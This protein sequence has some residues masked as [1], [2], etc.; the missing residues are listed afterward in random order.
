[1]Q[2]KS[3]R[4]IIGFFFV[5]LFMGVMFVQLS[6]HGKSIST[7]SSAT[8]TKKEQAPSLRNS[9]KPK[10]P[11]IVNSYFFTVELDVATA[12][13]SGVLVVN[14]TNTENVPLSQLVFHVHPKAFVSYGGDIVINTL[15]VEGDQLNSS[16]HQITD[17]ILEIN[18]NAT[19][20]PLKSVIITI[21]FTTT[22]PHLEDRFGYIL[23]PYEAYYLTNWYPVLAVYDQNGWDRSPYS[24]MG[25]SFYY[26]MSSYE[27]ILTVP[28]TFQVACSLPVKTQVVGVKKTII[29][30]KVTIRDL[31]F[32]ASPD[33]A[34]S[35]TTWNG[36]TITSYYF[37][38]EELE[39][40]GKLATEMGRQA[41]EIYSSAFG[42]YIWETLAIVTFPGGGGME[43]PG[44]VLIA[45]N[46]YYNGSN[47]LY[48][49]EVIVHEIAHQYF[50]F[51][52]GTNSY[53]E[54]FIDE[55]FAVWTS[56]YFLEAQ[57][58]TDDAK[59]KT[60]YRYK[61][62]EAYSLD[63]GDFK[64]GS[65]MAY[66]TSF[67]DS[68]PYFYTVYDK[69]FVVL[70]MLENYLGTETFL[71]CLQVIYQTF[72]G[73]NLFFKDFTS[74]FSSVSHQNLTWFFDQWYFKTGLPKLSLTASSQD[75]LTITIKV[76]NAEKDWYQL[77]LPL[78]IITPFEKL[79]TTVW[80]NGS[81]TTLS[82]TL[83]N[84]TDSATVY[85]AR[86]MLLL[87]T[88][89]Q[90]PLQTEVVFL[91]PETPFPLISILI[92]GLIVLLFR[93]W[94]RPSLR[95]FKRRS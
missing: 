87:R 73:S 47:F 59:E 57:N 28:K 37:D 89:Y 26:D 53:L 62:Y 54:P 58:R 30:E 91:T 76:T 93:K 78:E 90:T 2:K 1:M 38:D 10:S 46:T 43:Y 79:V 39:Y 70:K 4:Q 16:S 94:R 24:F 42:P 48:W 34:K 31:A 84:K 3:E 68:L 52:L 35:S 17:T 14:Y 13:I 50:P 81:E 64:L 36:T 88:F 65:S 67:G 72:A 61:V 12:S 75:G 18:L 63:K 56:I 83:T 86:N 32:A 49:E 20:L 19:L 33:F 22:I 25:E 82:F 27:M 60:A 92:G 44:L 85:L 6:G 80:I 95:N 41:L 77:P 23:S 21:D 7:I 29:Y 51:I 15:Q 11:T 8:S 45:H 66:W 9:V 5:L 71:A 40:R 74:I 69:G 55:P